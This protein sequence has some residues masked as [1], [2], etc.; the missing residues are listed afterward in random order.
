MDD[1][2]GTWLETNLGTTGRYFCLESRSRRRSPAIWTKKKIH[3]ER[4]N[5]KNEFFSSIIH[6]WGNKKNSRTLIGQG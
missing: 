4:M 6:N 2:I 3:Y 1:H 5:E